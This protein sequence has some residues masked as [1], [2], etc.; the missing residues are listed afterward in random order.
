MEEQ[1][2]MTLDEL[3]EKSYPAITSMHISAIE[4]VIS[5]Y[6]RN[7]V[8]KEENLRK[9]VIYTVEGK[10]STGKFEAVRRYK[11]FNILRKVLVYRWPG[12]FVPYIPPKR[13]FVSVT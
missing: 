12:C 13:K 2:S 11:E 5:I 10:D 9:H 8:V 7:P 6:V 3:E 1:E 4:S